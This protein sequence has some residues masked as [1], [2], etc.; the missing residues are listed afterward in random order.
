MKLVMKQG[1][2]ASYT[3]RQLN[4]FFPTGADITEPKITAHV[5]HALARLE[6]CFLH[7]NHPLYHNEEGALFDPLHSDQYC[8]FLYLLSNSVYR[9]AG[10]SDLAKKLFYLN[11]A[12]HA[13]NCMYDTA[14]PEVF[15][16]IHCVG[17]VLGKAS[18]GNYLAFRQNCTV[19]SIG[20][21]FPVIGSKVMFSAGS[22]VLGPCVIGNN[23]LIGASC[24]IVKRDI[25]DDSMVMPFARELY[26]RPISEAPISLHFNLS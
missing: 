7:I 13:F 3:A 16:L 2:L 10:H 14:L 1:E 8:Q 22:S 5:D 11:K 12:L 21:E 17:T 24:A 26:L 19:G 6:H 18:Y 9:D 23:V 4:H 25:P 20:G 15:W